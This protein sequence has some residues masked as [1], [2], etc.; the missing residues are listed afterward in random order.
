MGRRDGP[1]L[2]ERVQPPGQPA[3]TALEPAARTRPVVRRHCWVQGLPDI[4]GRC[5]GLLVEWRQPQGGA[6][7]QW[8]GRV[9]YVVAQG[10]G[11]PVVVEAW[12]P[13]EHLVPA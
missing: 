4:P 1:T 9:L 5:P 3:P 10:A 6:A 11:P 2:A 8:E 12:L 7:P 13:A